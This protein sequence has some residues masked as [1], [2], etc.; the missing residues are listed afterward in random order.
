MKKKKKKEKGF[1]DFDEG[2][3]VTVTME[4]DKGGS[5]QNQRAKEAMLLVLVSSEAR[6]ANS[7]D[8]D[9]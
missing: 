4:V 1:G 2:G 3:N 6:G 5:W 7:V 9:C 8:A